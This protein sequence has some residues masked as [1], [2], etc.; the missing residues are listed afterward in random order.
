MNSKY[1]STIGLSLGLA[2]FVATGLLLTTGS[3]RAQP[4][5]A[6]TVQP[7]SARSV[8][9][10]QEMSDTFAEVAERVKP[11]VVTVYSEK[12]VKLPDMQFPFGEDFPFRWFFGHPP[13]RRSPPR[14][15]QFRQSGMGSGIIVDKDG[16]ILTNHHVVRDMTDISVKLASGAR[17][18]AELVGSDPKTDLAVLRI[19]GKV[20]RDLVPAELGD[21]EALRV[22]DW[23]LAVGAPFGYEQTVTAGIISA[24]GRVGI[25]RS[26]DKY[27]DFIQ[28]DAAI[29]PGNSGGP[30]VNLRGQVIGIN[31]AIATSVGQFAGVGF[32]IP[33]NMAQHVMH[34]LITDG[35]VTRGYLGVIIQDLNPELAEQF[36]ITDTQGVLISQL[37][38]DTPAAQAGLRVGDVIR[39]FDGRAVEN[40][41]QLRNLVANTAPGKSVPVRVIRDGQERTVNVTVGE[42]PADDVAASPV[43]APGKLGLTVQPLT[44]E[45]AGELGYEGETGLVV[46]EV[47]DGS[48]AAAA[49]IQPGDLILEINRAKVATLA[50]FRAAIEKAAGK[51]TLLVLVKNQTGTRF[52]IL[53]QK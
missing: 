35:K 36:G 32:A 23:V 49:G 44:P 40:V 2:L 26:R 29:N 31:T 43:T 16:H 53:R 24:K 46:T 33:V 14:E 20:P 6:H 30:L 11:S 5:A 17:Y 22:G 8:A 37:N 12:S 15:R 41:Q 4:E 27:E 19:K 9:A 1:L 28:T 42:L 25:D 38:A 10:L 48:P 3:D 34:D 18:D 51:E 47:D 21:S 45:K 50:E 7:V 39:Q 52:A 13:D